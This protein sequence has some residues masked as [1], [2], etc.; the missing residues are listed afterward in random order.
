MIPRLALTTG[1]PAGVGPDVVLQAV[2]S[3]WPA[4]LVVLGCRNML[5][6]RAERLGLSLTFLPYTDGQRASLHR[7]G[8]V[9]LI[10]LPQTHDCLPGEPSVENSSQI[11]AQ[12]EIATDLC[13]HGHC[14]AM[15]T[16]PIQ[17]GIIN[18][19][20][21][22]FSG[23]TEFL[24][25]A[26]GAEQP[27]MLLTAGELKIALATT[28]LPL[29]E[30]PDAIT[31]GGLESTL[32]VLIS[33]LQE[34]FGISD[35]R[36]TVLGL[37]PH[38]GEEGHLGTEERQVISPVCEA[39]RAEGLNI[40]GPISA[41]TAF[42]TPRRKA[43]DAYLAMFHDQGLPIIKSE[44]FGTLVNATL[45]LPLIRTSVDHGTALGIAGT[46]K[47]SSGSLRAAIA[48]AI[49]ISE[50]SQNSCSHKRLQP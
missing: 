12:L 11:I 41:D 30:V 26:T 10:D 25:K 37:N 34:S 4:E 24:A 38:N 46:G 19:A 43:S 22:A 8:S 21:I 49:A 28:H 40:V 39:L 50:T 23:H 3:E 29:R 36:I 33:G 42:T 9:Y 2:M 44:G 1:E 32:R 15:V 45:G 7:P 20:G 48:L 35:P 27:V 17:K 5:V 6:K 47:A 16:A 13:L 18:D 31:E 14:H